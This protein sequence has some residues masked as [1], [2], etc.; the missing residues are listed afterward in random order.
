MSRQGRLVVAVVGEVVG[1]A[2]AVGRVKHGHLQVL[3][4]VQRLLPAAGAGDGVRVGQQ[5]LHL[6][7]LA[8]PV[9]AGGSAD[10][11]PAGATAPWPAVPQS[12]WEQFLIN[13]NYWDFRGTFGR[14]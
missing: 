2:V 9:E 8:S 12:L 13:S 3:G 4:L 1:G 6:P 11:S 14:M 10:A 7:R 5:G